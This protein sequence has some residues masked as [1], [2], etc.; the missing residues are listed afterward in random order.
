MNRWGARSTVGRL[1]RLPLRLIPPAAVV[2]VLTGPMRGMRWVAGSAPHG[3]WLGTLER[4]KLREF[5]GRLRPGMTVWDIGANVGLFALPSARVVGLSG[6]VYA[7]E[8]MARNIRLLRRHLEL[9]R[10]ANVEVCEEAV[11]EVTGVMWMAEGDSPSE[12]HAEPGGRLKVPAIALDD[13]FPES[14]SPPPD[15]VKIDVEGSETAVLRGGTCTFARYRPP[16]YLALHGES[17]RRAC[18]RMLQD[19]GYY[20]ASVDP[21]APPEVS[22]E[23]LAE[24]V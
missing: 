1:I 11:G 23:W 15:L 5:V 22:S 21:G 24:A 14:S 13:W 3:A 8:P 6:R 20:V 9:N 17:Q 18:R 2:P 4:P 7:F 10:L 12:F 16:V 19:W